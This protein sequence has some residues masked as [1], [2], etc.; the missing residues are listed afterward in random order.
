MGATRLQSCASS[1]IIHKSSL[2]VRGQQQMCRI[3]RDFALPTHGPQAPGTPTALSRRRVSA[4][5][6]RPGVNS[7]RTC[8]FVSSLEAGYKHPL[9]L[10]LSQVA[11]VSYLQILR[12]L[13]IPG[14]DTS[15]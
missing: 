3:A 13:L 8:L 11:G 14:Y 15:G 7:V 5:R 6:V 1:S 12:R 9:L 10:N 4:W 2:R